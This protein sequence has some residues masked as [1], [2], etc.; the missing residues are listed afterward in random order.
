MRARRAFPEPFSW[1]KHQS[2][3]AGEWFVGKSSSLL[4]NRI[5][6]KMS[7]KKTFERKL[8]SLE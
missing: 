7:G 5:R 3:S 8:K 4:H 2:E 1:T 6:K